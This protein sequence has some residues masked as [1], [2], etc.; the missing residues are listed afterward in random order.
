MGRTTAAVTVTKESAVRQRRR[1]APETWPALL[2]SRR[3]R[4]AAHGL[5][6][7]RRAYEHV[8]VEAVL[9]GARP[10]RGAHYDAYVDALRVLGSKA[11][12]IAR[13][14]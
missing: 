14:L 1:W 13:T 12:L 2:C 6:L 3:A 5:A 11:E 4:R 10:S 9:E 8:L 7:L